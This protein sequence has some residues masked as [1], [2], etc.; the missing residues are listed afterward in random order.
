MFSVLFNN[1]EY[2]KSTHKSIVSFVLLSKYPFKKSH[3]DS[4]IK[5]LISFAIFLDPPKWRQTELII[6]FIM[7]KNF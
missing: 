3:P 5:F 7:S 4:S 6:L 2:K 1:L